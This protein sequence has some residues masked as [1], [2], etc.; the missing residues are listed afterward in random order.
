[1]YEKNEGDVFLSLIKPSE[2]NVKY[3]GS[4]RL[5]SDNKWVRVK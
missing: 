3:V 2:W 1:L 5:E 4:A